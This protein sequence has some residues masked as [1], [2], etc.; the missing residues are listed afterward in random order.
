MEPPCLPFYDKGERP[1]GF[2]QGFSP[3]CCNEVCVSLPQDA[4]QHLS[5]ETPH[6]AFVDRM[7]GEFRLLRRLGRGGMAEVYLAEQRSLKRMVAVKLL[8]SDLLTDDVH[9]RRFE[10]EARAAAGL[11]HP[12]IVQVYTVGEEAGTHYIAQEYVHGH[13]LAEY[14]QKHGPP[15]ATTAVVIMT[16]V[17]GA[18]EAAGIA[19]IVHRDIKPE[20]VLITQHGNVK[21][22]D[23]GLAQ[24]T[25]PGEKLALTQAG[26]TM[27][28]PLYMSPEQISGHDLDQ[29]S[30][31]Y[32]FGVT[33]YHLLA[34]HPPFRGETSMSLAVQHVHGKPAPLAEIRPDLP[35]SVCYVVSRMM[36]K[37]PAE[38]YPDAAELLI[39]L[40]AISTALSRNPQEAAALKLSGPSRLSARIDGWVTETLP[41]LLFG[42]VRRQLLALPLVALLLGAIAAAVGY[43]LRPPG[44]LDVPAQNR[45]SE[46]PAESVVDQYYRAMSLENNEEAW[47]AVIEFFPNETRYTQWARQHLAR[48]YLQTDRFDEAEKLFQEFVKQ[49]RNDPALEARGQAGLA[50]IASARADYAA[51]HSIISGKL[52]PLERHLDEANRNLIIETIANNRLHL[53]NVVE[54][55][56]EDR[57]R[58]P[59]ENGPADDIRNRNLTLP[60][61]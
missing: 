41:Q 2:V 45:I 17:A 12:N 54:P 47:L 15:D 40:R 19:G 30:D 10:Q 1:A 44:P 59:P 48:L 26:M 27:G 28:T 46:R 60:P 25:G 50:V 16:Q 21:V 49:G 33:C 24:L 58:R 9:L 8:R 6:D 36:A 5:A 53:G 13:N 37:S 51:S 11:N 52:L 22:A 56:L 3:R 7:L 39:D 35:P 31:L 20:N 4:T 43:G 34:G 42:S 38:R 57:F 61:R 55:G 23:F 29:R 14:L 32:S 18:L